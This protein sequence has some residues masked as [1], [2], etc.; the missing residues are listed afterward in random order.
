MNNLRKTAK[1]IRRRSEREALQTPANLARR[2]LT[3]RHTHQPLILSA[4]PFR[5]FA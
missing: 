2:S 4:R 1:S 3:I 5:K